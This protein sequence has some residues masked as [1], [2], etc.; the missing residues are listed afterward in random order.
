MDGLECSEIAYSYVMNQSDIFRLDSF[1]FLKEFIRGENI[2]NQQP[3]IRLKNVSG[4][5]ILSFGA[6]SLN[7]FVEYL[8]SG[9]P[10]IRCV[11]MKDGLIDTNTLT[12]ISEAAHK[13][14]YKSEVFPETILVSMSGSIGKVAL[15]SPDWEYPINSN[16]DIAKIR[17]GENLNPYYVYT[18]FQTK[19]GQNFMRRE[20]RGSVQQHVFLSQIEQ[21]AVPLF[22]TKFY[23]RIEQLNR[24]AFSFVEQS[25][26]LFTDTEDILLSELGVFPKA[27]K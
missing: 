5:S 16:Q 20:A 7:N 10:F 14:L 1:Y 25:R 15:A 27:G 4:A 21:I 22:S 6:Y 8:D 24:T 19:Y 12:H 23:E 17:L 26:R 2:L 13:L 18:F 9:V 3:T 11:D